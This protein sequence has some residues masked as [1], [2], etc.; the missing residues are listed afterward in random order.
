MLLLLPRQLILQRS[1]GQLRGGA[2]FSLRTAPASTCCHS[3]GLYLLQ[4]TKVRSCMA[5]C[6]LSTARSS[7]AISPRSWDQARSTG[8]RLS[9]S[10]SV[11]RSWRHGSAYSF[12]PWER[13]YRYIFYP[14]RCAENTK[15]SRVSFWW[16]PPSEPFGRA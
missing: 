1:K 5:L 3:C 6:A 8:W 14:A 16:G 2:I 10:S 11:S 15:L 7:P 4:G 13:L 12:H 9:L